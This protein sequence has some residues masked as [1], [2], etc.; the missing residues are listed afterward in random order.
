MGRGSEM[1]TVGGWLLA[2]NVWTSDAPA[3]PKRSPALIRKLTCVPFANGGIVAFHT[4]EPVSGSVC[5]TIGI[6]RGAV[7]ALK[8]STEAWATPPSSV[9]FART[10]SRGSPGFG[11]SSTMSGGAS[12]WTRMAWSLSAA[13]PTA[14]WPSTMSR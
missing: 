2:L 9:M 4:C 11:G 10:F 12:S 6:S 7:L 5:R 13:L 1:R 8:N 14:S 3:L